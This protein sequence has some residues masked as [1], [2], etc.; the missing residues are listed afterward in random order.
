M[1]PTSKAY[2]AQ[3]AGSTSVQNALLSENE[4]VAFGKKTIEQAVNDFFT[5]ANQ[6]LKR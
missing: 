6:I 3:P 5:Q 1:L 2:P 4:A